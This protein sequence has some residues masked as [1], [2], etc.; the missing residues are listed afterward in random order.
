MLVLTRRTDEDICIGSDVRVRVL[1]IRGSQVRL[2]IDAPREIAVHR[3]EVL[4]A[5]RQENE[6]ASQVNAEA[7]RLLRQAGVFGKKG[8]GTAGAENASHE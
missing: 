3:G 6:A 8:S 1:S 7:L 4:D 2:G 5:I